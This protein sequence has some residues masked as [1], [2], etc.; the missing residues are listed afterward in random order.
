MSKAVADTFDGRRNITRRGDYVI[1]PQN[2]RKRVD[3]IVAED[4]VIYFVSY[5][6]N[7]GTPTRYPA[8][9]CVKYA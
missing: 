4:G 7:S 8:K 2:K 3:N 6:A 1:T 5:P 9:Q